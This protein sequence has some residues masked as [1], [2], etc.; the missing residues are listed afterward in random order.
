V[1]VTV[2]DKKMIRDLA[3]SESYVSVHDPRLHFGLGGASRADRIEVRWPDGTRTVRENVP[4]N[5]FLK[6][7]KNG[8]DPENAAPQ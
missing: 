4:A 6:V 1:T 3:S 8:S 2:G 5:A 7:R